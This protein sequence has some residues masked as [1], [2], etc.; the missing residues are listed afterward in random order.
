[1]PPRPVLAALLLHLALLVS[2]VA[3][4]RWE[5]AGGAA[6]V[7]ASIAFF[8][9]VAGENASQFT[10]VTALPGLLWMWCGARARAA[11]RDGGDVSTS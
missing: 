6:V 3:G 1:V 4:W 9:R 8:T 10:L 2:L 11:R 7:V 5:L